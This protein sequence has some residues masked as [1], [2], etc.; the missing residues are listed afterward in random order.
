MPGGRG[1]WKTVV[2][3]LAAAV[4]MTEAAAQQRSSEEAASIAIQKR[5]ELIQKANGAQA[6]TAMSRAFNRQTLN[7]TASSEVVPR[8]I[9]KEVAL[10][11]GPDAAAA[12]NA[13]NAL[14]KAGDAFYICRDKNAGGFVVVSGDRRMTD[15]LAYSLT[16]KLDVD[17]LPQGARALFLSY[18]ANKLYLDSNI[19][20]KKQNDS[21]ARS[22]GFVLPAA[23]GDGAGPL[24]STEWGQ[25]YPYNA[26]CPYYDGTHQAV[27][28]CVAT[29]MAQAMNYYKYPATG[30]GSHSYTSATSKLRLSKDFSATTFQ[31]SSMQNTYPSSNVAQDQVNA[32]ADLMLACGVSVDMDYNAESGASQTD[33]MAAL[34]KYFGYDNDMAIA[35]KDF[36]PL[37]AWHNLFVSELNALRPLMLSGYTTGGYGH[38]FI[39]DGYTPDGDDY[40]YYHV[41]WGWRGQGNGNYKMDNLQDSEHDTGIYSVQLAAIFNFMPDN[42]VADNPSYLQIQSV[43]SQSETVDLTNGETLSLDITQ[44]MNGSVKPFTGTITFYLVDNTG[45]RT[46]IQSLSL[47]DVRTSYYYTGTQNCSV[48]SS[49]PSGKYSFAATASASGSSKVQEIEIGDVGDSVVIINDKNIYYPSV[50]ATA[51]TASLSGSNVFSVSA[52]NVGN[53]ADTPFSGTLQMMVSDHYGKYITTFGPTRQLDNLAKYTHLITTYSFSGTL[54]QSLGDGAYRLNLGACQNGYNSWSAVKKYVIS[55]NMITDLDI[56]ATTPFWVNNGRLTLT[57]PYVE[58]DANQDGSLNVADLQALIRMI[59][60]NYSTRNFTF[61]AS[62]LDVNARLNVADFSLLVPKVMNAAGSHR[63]AKSR[64]ALGGGNAVSG[65]G[66]AFSDESNV[67]IGSEDEDASA[68]VSV[69]GALLSADDDGL[70][71]RVDINLNNSGRT[72]NAMQFD[73]SGD[74]DIEILADSAATASRTRGFRITQNDGRVLLYNM[75]DANISGEQGTILSLRLKRRAAQPQGPAHAGLSDIILSMGDDCSALRSR[76]VAFML[77][78]DGVRTATDGLTGLDIATTLAGLE[79]TGGLGVITIHSTES[80]SIPVYSLDGKKVATATVPTG[81]TACI[82]MPKGIYVVGNKKVTVR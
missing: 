28:G 14:N 47:S 55:N 13:L 69:D 78:A 68:L 36:M 81:Q 31:W 35:H 1:S 25:G 10:L 74:A 73:I 29:T 24:L 21:P 12:K 75:D 34:Q 77:D 4:C 2:A 80:A 22:H 26:L 71:Y 39:I 44:C 66:D 59:L 37:A 32:I 23:T 40:P 19:I 20:P 8:L 51:L 6:A 82:T 65:N 60:N 30:K 67:F 58:G 42:G 45:A 56:D 50:Q 53:F 76:D 64:T 33:Q 54:N 57:C 27:T 11:H 48:P 38:A 15:V 52:T 41:N 63:V 46:A 3:I 49:L 61:Y 9:E 79:I 72:V 5:A 16:D 17:S 62:D 18:V 43:E 70:T 7:I